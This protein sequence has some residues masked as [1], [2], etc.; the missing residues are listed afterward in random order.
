MD[1]S[2]VATFVVAVVLI[3]ATPGPAMALI[4]QRAARPHPGGRALPGGRACRDLLPTVLG[5]E[6]GIYLWA[7][8]AAAGF[9]SLV[10][11]SQVAYV[12]LKVVGA[13]VLLYLGIRA[14]RSAWRTSRPWAQNG[15][16]AP[17]PVSGRRAFG[18]GLVVQLANPK[19]AI[20]MIAFYP[21]FVG[22]D[23]PLF[24]TTAA[25]AV[26]QVCIETVLYLGLAAVAARA[27][28]YLRAPRFRA[29]LDAT[30]GTVLVGLGLR[31]A[32]LR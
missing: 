32:L 17:A 13:G 9:A 8:M 25:L 4:V 30:V 16:D 14:W 28:G 2:T 22:A 27:G 7:L 12:V 23:Q 6:L 11:A 24:L 10:A 19:A 20:F 18:E 29:R 5:L 21:Q 3:S 31:T 15:L 1:L 26:V